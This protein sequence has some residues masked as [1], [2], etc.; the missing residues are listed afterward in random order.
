MKA[1]TI[2]LVSDT[3]A[4]KTTQ[5]GE[6]ADFV[7]EAEGKHAIYYGSFMEH[8]EPIKPLSQVLIKGHPLLTMEI[9]DSAVNPWYWLEKTSAGFVRDEKGQWFKPDWPIGTYIYDGAS[10]FGEEL[11]KQCSKDAAAGIT[12][13]GF[14]PFS[15]TVGPKE[16]QI[17]IGSNNPSH[18]GVVQTKVHEYM[19]RSQ[20]LPAVYV[21]WTARPQ[22]SVDTEDIKVLGIKIAGQAIAMHVPAWFSYCFRIESITRPD[23]KPIKRLYI[24]E[25]KT[26]ITTFREKVKVDKGSEMR[27]VTGGGYEG[28]GNARYPLRAKT[29]LPQFIEPAD[30]VKALKLIREGNQEAQSYYIQKYAKLG[31]SVV[32]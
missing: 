30:V 23:Q 10:G 19:G 11:L 5:A 24:Q 25:H 26:G 8:P 13:G 20:E 14:K 32:K 18:F 27:T 31:A 22:A 1:S 2:L 12:I 16:D 7:M 15:T 21:V 17:A 4:G 6:V 28:Y 29:D 3:G 9:M